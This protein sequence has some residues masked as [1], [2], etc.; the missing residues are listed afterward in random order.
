MT[1][2]EKRD[3]RNDIIKV[4]M[5]LISTQGYSATGIGSVLQLAK[6]PKGSFYHYFPSKEAF[7]LAVIDRFAEGYERFVCA[8]LQE[9]GV[10]PL[11]RLRNYF[12]AVAQ[13]VG[14]EEDGCVRGCLIG[15]LGQELAAQNETFRLRLEEIFGVWL[16]HLAVTLDQARAAEEIASDLDSR[17]MAGVVL[18]GLQ[19]ALLRSKVQRSA[20]P[21]RELTA[22]LFDRLL[23]CDRR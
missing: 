15:N 7:G 12:D 8:F 14:L 11:Q 3:T 6:V 19:G 23:V 21:I 17:C 4:G 5:E 13:A 2:M 22:V 9:P 10:A 16:G 18:S 1:G 20:Q